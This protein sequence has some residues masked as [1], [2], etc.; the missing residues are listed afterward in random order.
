SPRSSLAPAQLRLRI[1]PATL[2]FAHTGEL[3]G[4]PLPWIGQERAAAAARFGLAMRQP[5]YHLFVLGEPGSGRSSLLTQAM[6]EAAALCP[7]PPDLS[8]LHHLDQPERQ[9]TLRLP[10][11]QGRV[12]RA[13]MEK[14]L[15]ARPGDIPRRLQ[16]ADYQAGS[17]ALHTRHETA[18]TEAFAALEAF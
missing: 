7:A 6:H 10:P 5:D 4:L 12:R 9:H 8:S 17:A 13:G 3:H 1:D 16:E 2:G 11:G 15:Q 18:Q 14:I